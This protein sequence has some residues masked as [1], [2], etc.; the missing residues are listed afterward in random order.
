MKATDEII[1]IKYDSEYGELS[2][3]TSHPFQMDGIQFASIEGFLQGLKF[4]GKRQKSVFAMSDYKAKKAGKYNFYW[5]FCSTLYYNG[6]KIDRFSNE[7][8]QLI[9]RAYNHMAE[10]NE[11]FKSTLAS[12]GQSTLDHS[13]GKDDKSDTVLTKKEFIDQLNRLRNELNA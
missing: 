5:R 4:K 12:T 6:T 2:N 3:F 13:I 10:Q 9:T 8:T 11:D 7:Y 1:D